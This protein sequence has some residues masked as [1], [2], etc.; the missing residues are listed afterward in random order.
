MEY[1]TN[2]YHRFEGFGSNFQGIIFDILWAEN[3]GYNYS[4][5]PILNF[6]HNYENEIDFN[7]KLNSF[8]NMSIAFPANSFEKKIN[9]T[10]QTYFFVENNIDFLFSTESC[11][12]IKS[13]FFADKVSL[14]DTSHTHVAIHIRRPN[15]RDNRIEGTN[16][17]DS[18]YLRLI[19][20]LREDYKTKNIMFHIYSQG[21]HEHFKDFINK[22]KAAIEANSKDPT[23]IANSINILLDDDNIL[24]KYKSFAKKAFLSFYN[25]EDQF[26]PIFCKINSLFKNK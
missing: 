26:D 14:F 6:D 19:N 2:G 3:N 15:V 7:D 20:I 18:Y 1:Y 22:H 5:T 21:D 13:A 17:P 24:A 11:K 10:V 8:M 25:F 4:F 12:K 9:P 23:S 16:T